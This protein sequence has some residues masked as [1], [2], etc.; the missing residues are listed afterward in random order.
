M[1]LSDYVVIHNR[2]N[3]LSSE[4]KL[5]DT[6]ELN[7]TLR[8][9]IQCR[10]LTKL[11][12][13]FNITYKFDYAFNSSAYSISLIVENSPILFEGKTVCP[14]KLSRKIT[15]VKSNINLTLPNN[16]IASLCD[17]ILTLLPNLISLNLDYNNI[18]AL[19]KNL[20]D[21]NKKLR[22]F[23]FAEN[24]A[25]IEFSSEIFANSPLLEQLFLNRTYLR[26]IYTDSKHLPV[27]N[28][29][30]LYNCY[31][32]D[33][34]FA[35]NST[36][37]KSLKYVQLAKNSFMNVPKLVIN[38]LKNNNLTEFSI[39]DNPLVC[40]CESLEFIQAFNVWVAKKILTTRDS[41]N[42][43]YP[44]TECYMGTG[45]QYDVLEIEKRQFNTLCKSPSSACH[46]K[47]SCECLNDLNN[48]IYCYE[49][50]PE[51]GIFANLTRFLSIHPRNVTMEISHT[52]LLENDT[53]ILFN[54][55][56]V[57]MIL[58]YDDIMVLSNKFLSRK[59]CAK[60]L[61]FK[62]TWTSILDAF[63]SAFRY[64][65]N[66]R[67]IKFF[68]SPVPN[69]TGMFSDTFLPNL[70]Y[71]SLINMGITTL[72]RVSF[73]KKL[74]HLSLFGNRFDQPTAALVQ[75]LP[76]I[77]SINTTRDVNC[78][79]KTYFYFNQLRSHVANKNIPLGNNIPSINFRIRKII[80]ADYQCRFQPIENLPD[81]RNIEFRHY[82]K[83]K[84]KY[85]E[86]VIGLE[87]YSMIIIPVYILDKSFAY[88]YFKTVCWTLPS[89]VTISEFN[90]NDSSKDSFLGSNDTSTP[91][92]ST[93]KVV[94]ADL[95]NIW[96]QK[97]NL[98]S[99]IAVIIGSIV[100]A[101]L[102]FLIIGLYFV[103]VIPKCSDLF[104][105]EKIE[106]DTPT[107]SPA[108]IKA[109]DDAKSQSEKE[110]IQLPEMNENFD[111]VAY[112]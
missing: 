6:R 80:G 109:E 81:Y 111:Y 46:V 45:I 78:N 13:L 86:F 56:I 17:N 97:S 57:N 108:E 19:P 93:A 61:S 76:N 53:S 89:N 71:L 106:S 23:S 54:L 33:N 35:P 26:A 94:P 12:P 40:D 69:I 62:V 38:L 16:A 110:K 105:G 96:D 68:D 79:C 3:D 99:K 8:L 27:L 25:G 52:F 64:C 31:I 18:S 48:D 67:E 95:S 55:N 83:L 34:G 30:S 49:L 82:S 2:N 75:S 84:L 47:D 42:F 10:N 66:L 90:P 1:R 87:K 104:A 43:V 14:F 100:L 63:P 39:Q 88:N 72:E 51:S 5:N 101:V 73:P 70:K 103:G 36:L 11:D 4:C 85:G 58:T 24:N 77:Q 112:Y 60:L 22:S 32:P 59:I 91:A 102:A 107:K 92:D 15:Y 28:T 98:G 7:K 9:Y 41:N 50:R 21:Y 44:P 74:A 29:L 65:G 20:F 37:P